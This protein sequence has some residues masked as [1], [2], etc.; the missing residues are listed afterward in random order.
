MSQ[1]DWLWTNFGGI[2]KSSEIGSNP[3]ALVTEQAVRNYIAN[4]LGLEIKL[5]TIEVGNTIELLLKDSQE[6]VLSKVSFNKGATIK[7]FDKFVSTQQDIENG[8]AT[9]VGI[10][11]LKIED[12][13]DNVFY[14]EL[15]NIV[16]VGSDTSTIQTTV[17]GN[18]IASL[19]KIDNPIVERS[20]DLKT[21]SEGLRADLIIDP[22]ST[23]TIEKG[24]DGVSCHHYW[25][26]EDQK[27]KF[28]AL[29]INEYLTLKKIDNGTLYFITDQPCIYFRTIKFASPT[30][31]VDCITK[32]EAEDFFNDCVRD[33]TTEVNNLKARLTKI[34][35]KS[36]IIETVQ[37]ELLDWETI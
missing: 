13:L 23:I 11:Y 20:V 16:Y 2:E 12:S 6:I 5:E 30:P 18:K 33:L 9:E 36:F 31:V 37:S 35:D 14:V 7:T 24:E 8:I 1:L 21:T 19:V 28:K 34:E 32:E 3:E 15:P 17:K 29:S 25:Q 10:L 27:I 26:G 4:Y 22:K